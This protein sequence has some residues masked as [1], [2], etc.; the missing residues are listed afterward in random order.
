MAVYRQVHISFWQ[1]DCI[2]E[3][4]PDEKF[5]YLYLM[6]NS[7][8]KQCGCYEIS[9]KVMQFETGFDIAKIDT[10]LDRFIQ[11]KKIEYHAPTK[12]ILLKNWYKHNSFKSPRVLTCIENEI[13][14]TKHEPFREYLTDTFINQS[15]SLS[16]QTDTEPQKE[17]K[18][19]K[20]KKK[21]FAPPTVDEVTEYCDE[22]NNSVDPNRFID[23]YESKGWMVGKN[24]MKCWKSAVRN[25]ER[26][27]KSED[28][29]KEVYL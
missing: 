11:L 3:L 13:K 21:K 4:T 1:D 15:D 20:E 19:E 26:G 28:K 18:E 22:R 2:L 25:W 8:T 9:K 17:Q 5:F 16:V 29:V 12:E 23:F 7:K 24:K 14:T 10:L 6:T 27:D